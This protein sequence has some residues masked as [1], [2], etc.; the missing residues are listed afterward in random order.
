MTR[1]LYCTRCET[2][3]ASS[4]RGKFLKPNPEL[5]L[6]DDA[7]NTDSE[8]WSEHFNSECHKHDLVIQEKVEKW[9]TVKEY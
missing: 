6:L 5:N 7:F 1:R 9:D 8:E 4:E 3:L 2:V